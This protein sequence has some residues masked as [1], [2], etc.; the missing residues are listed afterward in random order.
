MLILT[1]P[2]LIKDP[3]STGLNWSR[4]EREEAC[5]Q[6]RRFKTD[7]LFVFKVILHC[8]FIIDL[9]DDYF[10]PARLLASLDKNDVAGMDAA[11]IIDSPEP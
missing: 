7:P 9:C 11:S 1:L 3:A 5:F 10:A 2:P 6:F 4:A 8:P